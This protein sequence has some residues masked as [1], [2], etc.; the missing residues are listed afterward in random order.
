MA[1]M[2]IGSYV[3]QV[4]WLGIAMGVLYGVVVSKGGI[5]ESVS[6]GLKVRGKRQGGVEGVEKRLSLSKVWKSAGK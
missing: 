6:A 2:D 3:N 1:Q 4:L 5:I